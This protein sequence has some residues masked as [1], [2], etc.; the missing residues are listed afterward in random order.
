[1]YYVLKYGA[2]RRDKLTGLVDSFQFLPAK[3]FTLRIGGHFFKC[4]DFVS[5]YQFSPVFEKSVREIVSSLRNGFFVDVGANLGLYSILAS[6]RDNR[7]LALEPN[8][9]TFSC[10][11]ENVAGLKGAKARMIA[12]WNRGGTVNFTLERKS[13]V[14][15]VSKEGYPVACDRLDSLVAETPDIVKIDAEGAEPEIIEGLGAL[16]PKKIIFEA[17]TNQKLAQCT[18]LLFQRGYHVSKID[19]TNFLATLN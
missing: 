11:F 2:S 15:H 5:G 18:T 13:D 9:Y 7:I 19:K 1:M 17:L 3:P 4:P 12:A 8:P 14:S 16:R 6:S 10:L